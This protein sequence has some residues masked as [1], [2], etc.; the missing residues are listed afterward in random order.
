MYFSVVNHENLEILTAATNKN[1]FTTNNNNPYSVC[2]SF[3]I[4]YFR[5]HILLHLI[6][7]VTLKIGNISL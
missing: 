4:C 6:M 7:N 3:E 1:I 5:V 2:P